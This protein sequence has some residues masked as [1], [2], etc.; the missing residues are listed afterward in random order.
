VTIPGWP[1]IPAWEQTDLENLGAQGAL[2]GVNPL[3]LAVIDSA[4]SSGSGGGINSAGY[5]GFFGLGANKT[6]PG[7]TTSSAMLSNP[8]EQSFDEQ[9]VIAA[10]AFN[11]YLGQEGGDPIKAEEVYQSG[12][13]SGP[14]QGSKLMVQY[15]GGSSGG[16]SPSSPSAPATTV[17]L[18]LSPFDLF[19]I[20][21]TV[22]GGAAGA[23][24]SATWG[25]VGPF[26]VKA[27]LVMAGLA[28]IV[29]GISRAAKSSPMAAKAQSAAPLLAAA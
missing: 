17:G 11:Q 8:G 13:A 27:I 4:E 15:L 7:G 18:N 19:G 28:V 22:L 14:T 5:G 2:S 29:L 20:P 6:Y 26:L 10:S 23:V 21:Q 3:A 9:A 24:G 1:P 16:G 25:L 12:R